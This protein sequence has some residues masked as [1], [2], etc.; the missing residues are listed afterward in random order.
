M[1]IIGIDMK[2]DDYATL[3]HSIVS[4]A[5]V[6]LFLLWQPAFCLSYVILFIWK[7]RAE[8]WGTLTGRSALLSITSHQLGTPVTIIR[9]SLETLENR[10]PKEPIISIMRG[11]GLERI[12]DV[13][14]A[15]HRCR[16]DQ[17][18]RSWPASPTT[19]GIQSIVE[20]VKRARPCALRKPIKS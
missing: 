19:V 12:N 5:T 13:L 10:H 1:G 11:E 4:P 8:A 20:S 18:R 3:S 6:L 14:K 9:W 2:F 16:S 15:L 7:R 17:Q